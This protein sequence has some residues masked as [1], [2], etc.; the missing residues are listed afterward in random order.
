MTLPFMP[1]LFERYADSIR[2]LRVN[3]QNGIVK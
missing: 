3:R 1:P 2:S